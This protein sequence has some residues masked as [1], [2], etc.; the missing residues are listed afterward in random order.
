MIVIV[1]FIPVS[2]IWKIRIRA[3]QKIALLLSLGL[4]AIMIIIAIVRVSGLIREGVVDTIWIAYWLILGG[5]V[6]IIIAAAIAFR[7]FFVTLGHSKVS[8]TPH[9]GRFFSSTFAKKFRKR[10]VSELDSGN[11]QGL[12]S[13][14]GAQLTGMRTYIREKGSSTLD[15]SQYSKG[16]GTESEEEDG[17]PLRSSVAASGT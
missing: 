9:G 15:E 12:P 6:G 13:I 1:L 10:G 17:I 11:E 5:E 8:T 16:T 14:P 4:T 2:I 7:S 3:A